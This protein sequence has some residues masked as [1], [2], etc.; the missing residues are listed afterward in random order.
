VEGSSALAEVQHNL[1][2]WYAPHPELSARLQSWQSKRLTK[3][4]QHH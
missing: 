1:G 2:T 3:T 4:L